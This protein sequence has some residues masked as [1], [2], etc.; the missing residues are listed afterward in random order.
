MPKTRK[1]RQGKTEFFIDENLFGELSEILC[2]I[3][4]KTGLFLT[5]Y[6]DFVLHKNIIALSAQRTETSLAKKLA[7]FKFSTV[8]YYGIWYSPVSHPAITDAS[9]LA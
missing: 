8:V 4:A 6:S 5:P 7:I 2:E 9:E 1:Q 3:E